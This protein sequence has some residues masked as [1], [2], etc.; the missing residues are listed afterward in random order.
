MKSEITLIAPDYTVLAV[1]DGGWCAS[2]ANAIKTFD[3]HGPS[4]YCKSNGFGGPA[5]NQV[6]MIINE[7][8]QWSLKVSIRTEIISID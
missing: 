4:N 3:K 6:Y 2:S 8:G 7:P 5:A 1:Q